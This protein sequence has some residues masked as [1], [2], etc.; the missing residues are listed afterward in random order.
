MPRNSDFW[1]R[2]GLGLTGLVV[3]GWIL[4]TTPR[5][6][7]LDLPSVLLAVASLYVLT[8]AFIPALRWPR[9]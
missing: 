1:L 3:A 5:G 7:Y 8:S 4:S 2:F 6:Y 9:R